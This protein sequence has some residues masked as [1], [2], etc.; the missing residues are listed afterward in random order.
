MKRGRQAA[1]E[2]LEPRSLLTL[3]FVFNG[4]AF[5]KA[6]PNQLTQNTAALLESH[7]N[8]AIQLTMPAMD[9]PADFYE[10]VNEVR[11]LSNGQ[12]IGLI[13]FSA[14]GSLALRLAGVSGLN[15]KAAAAYYGPPDLREYLQYHHGDRDYRYVTSHVHLDAAII[16]LL[17][18]PSDTS[19]YLIDAFGT[20]D[21][22]VVAGPSTVYFNQDFPDGHVYDYVGPHGV[23]P[24]ADPQALSA[25]L[26]HL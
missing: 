23:S 11:S 25:F 14:G 5:A 8:R 22:N 1:I 6:T 20:R 24:T 12:P 4:N 16:D 2:Q 17:S 21:H 7:G 26:D 10:V 15:V 19:A 18:G 13:G 3:V 9:G